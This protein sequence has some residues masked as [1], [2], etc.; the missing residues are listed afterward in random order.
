MTKAEKESTNEIL[1]KFGIQVELG[2]QT[3]MKTALSNIIQEINKNEKEINEE[4]ASMIKEADFNKMD[5][6][7]GHLQQNNW[8]LWSALSMTFKHVW[9]NATLTGTG[10]DMNQFGIL[11]VRSNI[12]TGLQAWLFLRENIVANDSC[13][14]GF[15][16]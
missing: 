2:K 15:D 8:D 12:K 14:A 1:A 6:I 16:T 11:F 10:P 7:F 9:P 3:D 5:E 4:N 13:F